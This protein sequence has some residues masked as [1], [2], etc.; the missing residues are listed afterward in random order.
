[1]RDNDWLLAHL[2]AAEA[3]LRANPNTTRQELGN[4]LRLSGVEADEIALRLWRM[5]ATRSPL[6]R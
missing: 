3:I 1:M 5:G 2:D 4:R 6:T